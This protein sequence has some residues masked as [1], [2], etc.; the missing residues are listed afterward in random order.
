MRENMDEQ[1]A[2]S[3]HPARDAFEQQ[4]VVL[5]MLEHLDGEHAVELAAA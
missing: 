3:L 2:I 1:L 4:T 5:H